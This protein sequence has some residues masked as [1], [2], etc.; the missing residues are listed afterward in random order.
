MFTRGIAFNT[1]L[2]FSTNGRTQ[3]ISWRIM[4]IQDETK[5]EAKDYR[6]LSVRLEILI[7]DKLV[8]ATIT[9]Y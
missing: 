8:F 6:R 9:S 2:S 4:R 5:S 7:V 1:D 3:N